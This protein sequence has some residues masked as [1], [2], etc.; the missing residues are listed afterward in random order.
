LGAI[1][2][3]A[4]GVARP[5]RRQVGDLP[6]RGG[7]NLQSSEAGLRSVWACKGV[8]QV[9]G[10][11]SLRGMRQ[12]VDPS[13]L[14]REWGRSPATSTTKRKPGTAGSPSRQEQS[15]SNVFT[16]PIRDFYQFLQVTAKTGTR[17]RTRAGPRS[18]HSYLFYAD[19]RRIVS[20]TLHGGRSAGSSPGRSRSGTR[21]S[22]SQG[23]SQACR[24][25]L[26]VTE[27]GLQT[28]LGMNGLRKVIERL[29]RQS[30]DPR[31]ALW[32]L[33]KAVIN[34]D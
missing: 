10:C 24:P 15:S 26:A 9:S 22:G 14:M 33:P 16:S 4:D 8:G 5:E 23:L 13:G 27:M 7:S 29:G 11:L 19:S 30:I 20:S 6:H 12:G 32:T 25:A 3:G 2:S 1:G 28:S 31:Q 18:A 34:L 17:Q 21:I